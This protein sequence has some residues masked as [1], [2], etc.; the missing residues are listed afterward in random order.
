[1]EKNR[2]PKYKRVLLKIS[3]EAIGGPDS[4]FDLEIVKRIA[5]E[6]ALVQKKGVEIGLVIG[7]GNIIRGEKLAGYGLDRNMSDYMG[8]TAT[9][10]NGLLFES[11]LKSIGAPVILQSALH[12]DT[13]TESIDLNKTAFYLS[14]KTIVIFAAGTGNPYFTTDTAAALR[15]LEINAQVFIKATKVDGV[16]DKDPEVHDDARFYKT[17]T[18]NDVL[19][20]NLTVMDMTAISLCR[21]GNLPVRVFNI[22]QSGNI[23]RIVMGDNLGTYIKE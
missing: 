17:L 4:V 15:A 21:D 1:M 10:I 11:I 22:N 8:M 7:G 2:K 20:R 13:V 3:G 19:D 23:V 6:I 5:S 12:I 18:Y 14:D 9:I 16:F